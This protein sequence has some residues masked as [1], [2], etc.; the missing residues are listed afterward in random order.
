MHTE[1][2]NRRDFIKKAALAGASIAATSTMAAC[3][4]NNQQGANTNLPD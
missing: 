4:G 2:N 3:A 1:K